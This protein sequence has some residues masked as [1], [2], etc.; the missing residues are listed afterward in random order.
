[1]KITE[2]VFIKSASGFSDYPSEGLPEVAFA[3]RSNVGKSSL[4][5]SL[6]QMPGLAHTSSSPGCTRMINFYRVNGMFY[7]ADL[8]GYGYARISKGMR[9]R[10]K[11]M[12]EEYLEKREQL[13]LVVLVIDIRRGLEDEEEEFLWWLKERRIKSLIVATKIDKLHK[14]EIVQALKIIKARAFG[15]GTDVEVFSA[16]TKQGRDEVLR[17][18]I[19]RLEGGG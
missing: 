6:V 15:F 7:F 1:M 14:S 10:W 19:Q 17:K 16:R 4:I 11:G 9:K 5:N 2:A 12:I 3:G 8:P 13:R 18:I